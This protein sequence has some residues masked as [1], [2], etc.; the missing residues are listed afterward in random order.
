MTVKKSEEELRPRIGDRVKVKLI[1][2]TE[3]DLAVFL[4]HEAKPIEL[5]LFSGENLHALDIV[6]ASMIKGELC[7][8]SIPPEHAV[9]DPFNEE[10][11]RVP[12]DQQLLYTIELLDWESEF[13]SRKNDGGVMRKV[14][15][16]GVGYE[17][18][19]LNSMVTINLTGH[20]QTRDPANRIS[21]TKFDQRAG[22]RFRLGEGSEVAVVR[23]LEFAIYK[24]KPNETNRVYVL[25]GYVLHL[26]YGLQQ[27]ND[28][29]RAAGCT[30]QPPGDY[31]RLIYEVQLVSFE[32]QKQ[33]WEMTAEER[34]A[35][36]ERERARGGEFFKQ[37][38][39][40]LSLKCYSQILQAIGPPNSLE[41]TD[42]QR[43]LRAELLT[44]AYNNIALCYLK[45]RMP[46]EALK[47][48]D[49]TLAIDANNLKAI[50]RKGLANYDRNEFKQAIEHFNRCLALDPTNRAARN[51]IA[52]AQQQIE[53]YENKEKQIFSR[54][55]DVLAKDREVQTVDL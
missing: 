14:L 38:N 46:R 10:C 27:F 55:F 42:E 23:G 12:R 11:E 53:R 52:L 18:P 41:L 24:M 16:K 19:T 13:L 37:N 40:Q 8:A 7:E 43:S 3:A 6:I 26:D 39:L 45:L 4:A 30:V 48:A 2:R 47:Y 21:L 5:N 29:L 44:S 22:L 36:C 31:E 9:G 35:V 25:P 51:Q 33:V 1:G 50:Y 17:T 20:F 15:A 54:L 28:R 34:F 49:W 32:P